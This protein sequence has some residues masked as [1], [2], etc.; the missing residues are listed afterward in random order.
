MAYEMYGM[1][2]DAL[3]DEH[4]LEPTAVKALLL[5]HS[6]KYKENLQE[7]KEQEGATEED[8]SRDEYKELIASYKELAR[9]SDNEHIKERALRFLIEEKKGRNDRR[10][11]KAMVGDIEQNILIFNESIKKRRQIKSPKKVKTL[12][13]T[14]TGDKGKNG[15]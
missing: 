11:T 10:A 12:E 14:E 7:E 8:I 3:A 2:V 4:S 1:S 15:E 6:R 9:F 13:M 5:R